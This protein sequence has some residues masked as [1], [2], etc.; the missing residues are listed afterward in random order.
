MKYVFCPNLYLEILP[1]SLSNFKELQKM[2]L[3][4][5]PYKKLQLGSDKSGIQMVK[6]WQIFGFQ[7][8]TERV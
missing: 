6:N 1:L 7:M 3:Q 5:L 4:G 2:A 8:V